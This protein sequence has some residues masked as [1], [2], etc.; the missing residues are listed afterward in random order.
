MKIGTPMAI[1]ATESAYTAARSPLPLSAL[2]HQSIHFAPQLLRRS[3]NSWTAGVD[4]N[5]PF[6]GHL[7]QP[8]P[9]SL[10][11][12]P[13]YA[14]PQ[15]GFPK[16]SRHGEPQPRPR[17]TRSMTIRCMAGF[18]FHAQAER[19]KIAARK[20]SS[21]IVGFA[22]IGGSQDPSCLGIRR[23]SRRWRIERLSRR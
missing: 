2:R 10:P 19:G 8:H 14:I 12:S 23:P 4:H 6:R 13:L 21:L 20:S 22:E 15:H 11:Q 18:S 1:A 7:R 16:S 17:L 5:V 9:Q 3:R